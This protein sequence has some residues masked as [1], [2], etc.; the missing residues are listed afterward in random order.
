MGQANSNGMGGQG[1]G[2]DKKDENKVIVF[3]DFDF[4]CWHLLNLY[5][6]MGC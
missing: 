3:L 2:G 1:Q 6:S 4:N 5:Y